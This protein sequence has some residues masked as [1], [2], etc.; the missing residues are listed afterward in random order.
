MPTATQTLMN[1]VQMSESF[2]VARHHGRPWRPHGCKTN[3][4]QLQQCSLQARPGRFLL[5]CPLWHLY[6][7]WFFVF[8]KNQLAVSFW[9]APLTK[10]PPITKNDL[11]DLVFNHAT[12]ALRKRCV[13]VEHHCLAGLVKCPRGG[14]RAIFVSM[15]TSS[16]GWRVGACWRN[17][18]ATV[19]H[20]PDEARIRV[21]ISGCCYVTDKSQLW[22]KHRT[23]TWA[24][25]N[26][27]QKLFPPSV[28]IEMQGLERVPPCCWP[29]SGKQRATA[30]DGN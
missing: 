29:L 28:Q 13:N 3:N 9:P 7:T 24:H 11:R 8:K 14:R 4:R 20:K 19:L 17:F 26:L 16:E 23:E 27:L 25:C 1:L 10:H 2:L 18:V 6:S 15:A 12:A 30:G 22:S 21:G 5:F